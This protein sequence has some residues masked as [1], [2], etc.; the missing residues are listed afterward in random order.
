MTVVYFSLFVVYFVICQIIVEKQWVPKKIMALSIMKILFLSLLVI[1][2]SVLI[3][4]ALHIGVTLVVM[5][6]ILCSS[7]IAGKYRHVFTKMEEGYKQ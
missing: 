2:T 5:T 6:T 7:V 4:T 1:F 3:G